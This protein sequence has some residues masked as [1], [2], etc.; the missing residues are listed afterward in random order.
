MI[1]DRSVLLHQIFYTPATR[2]QLASG[3]IPLDNTGGRPDWHEFWPIRRF[4]LENTLDENGFYG[5][6]SPKFHDK[7]GLTHAQLNTF[8]AELPPGVDV[9]TFSTYWDFMAYFWNVIEHGEFS[10]P[11]FS[12]MCVDF[13]AEF[14]PGR[15]IAAAPNTSR[16]T[17]YG[18]YFAA[19][20]AFWRRWLEICERLFELAE[21]RDS[22]LGEALNRTAAYDRPVDYKV[23]MMERVASILLANEPRW[24]SVAYNPFRLKPSTYKISA[25]GYQAIISDALKISHVENGYPEY[26]NAYLKMRESIKTAITGKPG[27]DINDAFRRR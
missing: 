25:F 13:W 18:N 19:R 9:A 26:R 10:H 24:R 7:T 8:I 5:F 14:F 6:F 2:H 23:F 17:I 3:F 27:T 11:G 12:A 15:D 22:P 20:P 1:A 16:N 4:L 21:R